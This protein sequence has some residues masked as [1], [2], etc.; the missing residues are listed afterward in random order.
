M[1]FISALKVGIVRP[2]DILAVSISALNLGVVGP[3]GRFT[4]GFYFSFK[5]QR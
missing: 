5:S 1:D 3:G 2:R 4:N